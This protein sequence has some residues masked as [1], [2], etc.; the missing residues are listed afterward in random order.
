MRKRIRTL[1]LLALLCPAILNAQTV[2]WAVSPTGQ[3]GRSGREV[4]KART[5]DGKTVLMDEEGHLLFADNEV[6]DSI[7][8]FRGGYAL[9]MNR[10]GDRL[11]IDAVI[12]KNGLRVENVSEKVYAG[13]FQF[14]SEGLM[15]VEGDEGWGYMDTSG[16]MAI[17]CYF[18]NAYP[19]SRGLAAVRLKGK[20]Y[21][22]NQ[23]FDFLG[24]NTN[25]PLAYAF[26]FTG[27]E[28]LV[29]TTNM[30]AYYVDRQ[31]QARRASG[32]K[33][34]N[35]SFN[36]EDHTV[37]DSLPRPRA[38]R[39]KTVPPVNTAYQRFQ[40]GDY[41]G[42]KHNGV[43]VV[44]AQFDKA[45][46]VR[47]DFALVELN[48]QRGTIR[49]IDGSVSAELETKTVDLNNDGTLKSPVRMRVSYPSALG[50]ADVQLF[51]LNKDGELQKARME[52]NSYSSS[53]F[54]TTLS[55]LERNTD[56]DIVMVVVVDGL[57]LWN[58]VGQLHVNAEKKSRPAQKDVNKDTPAPK[59]VEDS[60]EQQ[61]KRQRE[62]HHREE[63]AIERARN[64][65][66]K[67]TPVAKLP[68]KKPAK[69]VLLSAPR[70]ANKGNKA[71]PENDFYVRVDVKNVGETK[72]TAKVSLSV[73]NK[74]YGTRN[75]S[76]NPGKSSFA[77]FRI[78]NVKKT[79]MTTG[80]A[81]LQ[82]GDKK[83]GKLQLVPF[84]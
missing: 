55:R 46:E 6:F 84:W 66:K 57:M 28:A 78:P 49:F 83:T 40:N 69:F 63:E 74:S 33:A 11:R 25:Y 26:T 19:F 14:F 41:W 60:R 12:H 50:D 72:G 5:D 53:T 18:Q 23:D 39:L 68:P 24:V 76:I 47:G 20:E 44:P 34:D 52:N 80:T 75:L 65:A 73:N 48:G 13:T 79:I 82:N 21:Y 81:S 56:E 17:P 3:G 37:G 42:Y 4:L 45:G 16:N 2:R 59:P 32:V 58:G 38:E 15:P 43:V 70:G 10:D 64:E 30:V 51:F 27:D 67:E 7:S 22:I 71:T 9:A 36:E 1:C 29:L 35:L 61:E 31:G 54:T 77:D 8:D 62:R